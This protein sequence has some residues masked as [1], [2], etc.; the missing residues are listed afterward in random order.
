MDNIFITYTKKADSVLTKTEGL[1][2]AGAVSIYLL[3]Q[4]VNNIW[5]EAIPDKGQT[6]ILNIVELAMTLGLLDKARQ[7]Y[8]NK[9]NKKNE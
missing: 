6:I 5:P 8:N 7:W 1:K 4:L 9:K 3:I 2:T